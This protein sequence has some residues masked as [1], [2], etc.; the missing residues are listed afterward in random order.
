MLFMIALASRAEILGLC[1]VVGLSST[2]YLV[3]SRAALA[4]AKT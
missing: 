1:A 2:V 3:Q 4:T